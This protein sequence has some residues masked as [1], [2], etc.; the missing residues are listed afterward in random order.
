[1]VQ[2]VGSGSVAVSRGPHLANGGP[3]CLRFIDQVYAQ[4]RVELAREG[5]SCPVLFHGR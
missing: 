1:M 5:R 4:H 3:Q 2:A